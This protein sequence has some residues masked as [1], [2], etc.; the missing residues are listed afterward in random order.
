MPVSF[1]SESV[2]A[3]SDYQKISKC[4][5]LVILHFTALTRF[6]FGVFTVTKFSESGLPTIL[7]IFLW[8]LFY[9]IMQEISFLWFNNLHII[10]LF[11]QHSEKS[12]ERS[13]SRSSSS[14]KPANQQLPFSGD[15]MAEALASLQRV[16]FSKVIPESSAELLRISSFCL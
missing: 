11:L 9:I 15:P 2:L 12:S 13:S 7:R 6:E 10:F 3:S 14:F 5:V 8:K 16:S 1:F 4:H